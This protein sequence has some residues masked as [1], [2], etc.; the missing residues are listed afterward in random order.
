[1]QYEEQLHT[2][3]EIENVQPS[4]GDLFTAMMDITDTRDAHL[5]EVSGPENRVL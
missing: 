5:S 3:N 2:L 1:M 4:I